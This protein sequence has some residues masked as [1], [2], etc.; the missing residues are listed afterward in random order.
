MKCR[1][2]GAGVSEEMVKCSYCGSFLPRT[3]QPEPQ[4]APPPQEVIHRVVH[5]WESADKSVYYPQTSDKSKWTAFILCFIGGNLGLHRFYARRISTG[6]LYLFTFGVF[7]LGSLVD[8]ILI[9]LGKFK[10][11]D[12]CRLE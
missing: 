11:A 3:A 9:L 2:C 7:G 10:D 8:L 1:N 6:I 5:T 4:K 12:G